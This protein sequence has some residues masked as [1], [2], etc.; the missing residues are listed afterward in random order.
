[1]IPYGTDDIF[2]LEMTGEDISLSKTNLSGKGT[3]PASMEA[4]DFAMVDVVNMRIEAEVYPTK[5][6]ITDYLKI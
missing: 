1:M 6:E 5:P 3:F 2:L 4:I